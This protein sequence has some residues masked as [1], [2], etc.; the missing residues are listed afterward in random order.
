MRV[1]TKQEAKDK[2]N[3]CLNM[4]RMTDVEEQGGDGSVAVDVDHAQEV[5]QVAFSGAH[6]EEPLEN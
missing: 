2:E 1:K 3:L 6:E 5:G 4:S